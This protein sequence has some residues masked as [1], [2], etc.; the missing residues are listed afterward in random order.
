MIIPYTI[1]R[2]ALSSQTSGATTTPLLSRNPRSCAIRAA[3]RSPIL[4]DLA[5][6]TVLTVL[7]PDETWTKVMTE[8]GIIGYVKTKALGS[9]STATR[10]S[11]YTAEEF[12]HIKKDFSINLGWHQVTNSSANANIANVL[13][14]TKGL[15]VISPTW[16]Y[17]KD[18][19]GGIGSLASSDYVNY[20]HQNNI[21]VWALVSNFGAKDQGLESPDTTQVLTYS[22]RRESLINNL[23]S[24]AIQYKLD[25]INVDFESL[26][27]SI[28]D[29]YIQFIREL[30]LKCANNGIVLSVDNYPPTAYTAFYNRSEQA[31]FADYV[32]LMGYDEHYAGSEE[33]GS[34]SSI[35]FVNQGVADTLQSV[36]ADQLILGMPFYTRVWSETP[37]SDDGAAV[38]TTEDTSDSDTLYE[39][40]CYSAGMKEVQNLIST[41][42][43]V[44]VWSDTDGQYYVEYI[45]GGVTYK[46]WVEDATSLE[47][48][49][50]VMQS[51][52]LAGG[53]F[54]KLGLE[55]PAVWD[56]IIK[57]IN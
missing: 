53:A 39:L 33:A 41:N 42:G 24:A 20:C 51:N 5:K 43:A 30:S 17:L 12:S 21:E 48:K 36:P 50:K 4:A 44:P 29:S 47:E 25:G 6:G 35:G 49:L 15:N 18:T 16:F 9:T 54:W 52:Q 23:I 26:D 56:T 10:T 11:D 55:D 46:I 34:V 38:S 2:T 27:P 19:N 22:S 31:V 57:Y 7:E 3:S 40:D 13:S 45:N 14:N 37:V 28:G 32:I 1:S 8:D